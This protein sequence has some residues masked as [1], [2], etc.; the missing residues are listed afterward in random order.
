[1]KSRIS[2]RNFLL[3]SSAVVA[4]SA[5]QGIPGTPFTPPINLMKGALGQDIIPKPDHVIRLSSN[6]NPW[7]PSRAALRAINAAIDESNLYTFF[8]HDEMAE[9]IGSQQHIGPEHISVGSGSGEIL[10][11]G[12][13]LA[14]MDEGSIV[15]PDPTF[16]DL[17]RYAAD[18]GSDVIRV[19]VND[20]METDLEAMASTIRRDT[21]L[22][23]ICNP[24]NPI[25]N[26]IEKNKLRDFVLEISRDRM[27]FVDEAYHEFVDNPD[28]SSM[29]DLIRD[30]H[31][32]IIVARTA[33][34]IHG[35]AGLRVGFG[36][37]HPDLAATINRRMTGTLNIIGLRAAFA[38]YR[39]EEHANFVLRTNREAL[40]IAQGYFREAGIRH[41]DSNG[42]FTFVETGHEI[43]EVQARFLEHNIRVGR[44]FPPFRNWMRLSMG[45]PD[46]MRYFVQTYKQLYG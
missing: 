45:T 13:L 33:S 44:P 10:K 32:N 36:F 2:R 1:M 4:A 26:I 40:D 46:E 19:P 11:M 41:I 37:S 24:N 39:D 20:N 42:N 25:P 15:I 8:L 34:K 5:M 12:G 17:P 38:S 30:G 31:R 16:E 14:T 23:Y 18:N 29:M 27:V 43:T 6:E 28:Y 9:L 35:L 22:V 7:G 3:G 21:K